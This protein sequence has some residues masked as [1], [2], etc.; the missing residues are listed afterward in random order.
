[1]ILIIFP[2]KNINERIFKFEDKFENETEYSAALNE[3]Q[4]TYEIT[5]P[6]TESNE[7]RRS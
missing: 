4:T 7:R 3:F 5:Y 6:L 2:A 1:V